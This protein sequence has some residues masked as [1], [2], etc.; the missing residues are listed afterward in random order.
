MVVENERHSLKFGGM[1]EAVFTEWVS[2]QK[3]V[4]R[5]DRSPALQALLTNEDDVRNELFASGNEASSARVLEV[6]TARGG[7]DGARLA[8][9]AGRSGRGVW[10][11]AR[12]IP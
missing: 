7:A 4:N 10:W 5:R 8:A 11:L 1:D 12:P 2:T 3:K 9:A 6:F